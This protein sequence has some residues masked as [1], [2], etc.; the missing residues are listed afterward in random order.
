M[1][2][3]WA[4]AA[5]TNTARPKQSNRKSQYSRG[6]KPISRRL[7]VLVDLLQTPTGANETVAVCE[8]KLLPLNPKRSISS[9]G[10]VDK[11]FPLLLA[12]TSS[13]ETTVT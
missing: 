11:L 13:P 12:E 1:T 5:R 2:P 3:S 7:E 9:E 10:G 8:V 4:S 6:E